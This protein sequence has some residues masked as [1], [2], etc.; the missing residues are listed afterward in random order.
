MKTQSQKSVKGSTNSKKSRKGKTLSKEEIEKRI[1]RAKIRD[2]IIF[3]FDL[4]EKQKK[5]RV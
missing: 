4:R 1:K 3:M 5:A 2:D